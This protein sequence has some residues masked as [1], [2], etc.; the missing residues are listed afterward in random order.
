VPDANKQAMGMQKWSV[1]CNWKFAAD[2]IWDWYHVTVTHNSSG[3]SGA[4][5]N[6]Y[7]QRY[8]PSRKYQPEL[9]ALGEYGHA[10]GGAARGSDT[11][12]APPLPEYEALGPVGKKMGGFGGIFPNLWIEPAGLVLRVPIS[13]SRT[14]MWRIP[15]ASKHPALAEQ[16]RF[17]VRITSQVQGP[18]GH[19]EVD[20]AENWGLSTVGTMGTM[21]R[22]HPLNYM[23]S[24]GHGKVTQEEGAPPYIESTN[25]TEHGQRW[26]YRNWAH[27]MSAKSWQELEASHPAVPT[28]TV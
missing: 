23:M 1:P 18:G 3:M 22:R 21:I 15:F 13:P 28:G 9:V 19:F 11:S 27:W 5:P 2:N 26:H 10:I 7:V 6:G 16:S 8:T 24:L 4:S 25:W 17:F 12:L 14:E 20:D